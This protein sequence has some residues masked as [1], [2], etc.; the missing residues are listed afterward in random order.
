MMFSKSATVALAFLPVAFSACLNDQTYKYPGE[1]RPRSCANIR[2]KEE[3]RQKLC[4]LDEVRT[5]CPQTCGL[6]CDDDPDF[7]FPLLKMPGNPLRDCTWID[8][9]E[10]NVDIRRD[11]Y[12]GIENFL[13]PT[14]IR[15][16]CPKACDFCQEEVTLTPPSTPAPTISV[17]PNTEPTRPPSPMPSPFPTLRPTSSPSD[18]P[19]QLPSTSPSDAPSQLP[20]ESPSDLPSSSPSDSPS[21]LPSTSPS[22]APSQSPSESP[23]D[24]PSSS[25][26]AMP[27]SQPSNMPSDLPSTSPSDAPSDLPSTSPSDAP[28]NN[29]TMSLKPSPLPS[30]APGEVPVPCSD[31]PAFEFTLNNFPTTDV[32]CAW[33]TKN[34]NNSANRIAT[35][36]AVGEI[37]YAGCPSTCGGCTCADNPL[38]TFTLTKQPH[39]TQDCLWIGKNNVETRR[40]SYCDAV[41]AECP[42]SCGYCD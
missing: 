8:K 11:N 27:S 21:Q 2:I 5:A 34:E 40:E 13:G 39:I 19:S 20:S 3:R 6:C 36:C 33:L 17:S 23:S 9:N 18:S 12:C 38:F 14:T 1:T 25:P 22:D 29:P 7:E 30:A 24:S 28:S 26:S 42:A 4:L 41:G 10:N 15:N 32:D 31:D 37:K 35:Y 16:M